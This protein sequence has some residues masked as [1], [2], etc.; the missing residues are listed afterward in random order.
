MRPRC[1]NWARGIAAL[2]AL[3]CGAATVLAQERPALP[4][5][6]IEDTFGERLALV[7]AADADDR[8]IL[9]ARLFAPN[10]GDVAAHIV[11]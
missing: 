4:R 9:G 2:A 3:L 5:L 11:P 1:M 10:L 8:I 6:F 7:T